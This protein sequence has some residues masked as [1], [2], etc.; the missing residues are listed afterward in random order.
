VHSELLLLNNWRRHGQDRRR[1]L[2]MPFDQ[3]SSAWAFTG[4]AKHG[5]DRDDFGLPVSPPRTE[6]LAFDWEWYG[7]IHPY[8]VPGPLPE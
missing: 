2:G 1:E 8:E 6:L 4:W 5:R 7:L 3:Y